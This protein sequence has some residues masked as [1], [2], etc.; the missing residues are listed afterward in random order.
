MMP[1]FFGQ[2]SEGAEVMEARELRF[3]YMADYA[4]R[5]PFRGLPLSFGDGHS[6]FPLVPCRTYGNL[7]FDRALGQNAA[8]EEQKEAVMERERH[9]WRYAMMQALGDLV[10][11]SPA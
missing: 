3:M 8:H 5:D 1:R 11:I 6:R 7:S 2:K 10:E 4:N 9:A